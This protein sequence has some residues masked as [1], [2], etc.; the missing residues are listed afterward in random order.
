MAPYRR[1]RVISRRQLS[2]RGAA[3]DDWPRRRRRSCRQCAVF[4]QPVVG[5]EARRRG[6]EAPQCV[7]AGKWASAVHTV[8]TGAQRGVTRP[9]RPEKYRGWVLELEHATFIRRKAKT[10]RDRRERP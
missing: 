6:P 10:R 9:G 8:P 5:G 4:V 7:G 2:A 1:M 3:A